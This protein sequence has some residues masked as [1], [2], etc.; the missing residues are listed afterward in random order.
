[1]HAVNDDQRGYFWNKVVE[2]FGQD[3]AG[4]TLAFWGV[5]FKP[6][7]DDIREAPSL[8]LMRRALD[9]K[10]TVRAFDPVAAGHLPE[11]LPEVIV[12][13]DMYEV[14]AGCDALV[15]CTEWSEFR[16]PDFSRMAAVMRGKVIFDGRN[17]YKRETMQ[18]QG[19]SYYS[20]GRDPVLEGTGTDRTPSPYHVAEPGA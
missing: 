12:V 4:R 2:H 13:G 1:M 7:T 3:L 9:A 11:V 19:F 20:V 18:K 16:Q 14:L 17:L 8:S 6:E 5:A 15:I 10:A